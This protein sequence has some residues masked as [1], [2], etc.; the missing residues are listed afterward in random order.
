VDFAVL[1]TGFA[2]SIC[3]AMPPDA[4]GTFIR[5]LEGMADRNVSPAEAHIFQAVAEALEGRQRGSTET[6]PYRDPRRSC[7]TLNIKAPG[8][9]APRALAID[10]S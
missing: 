4:A 2:V 5:S 7:V 3:Q 10:L 6:R 8:V 1:F 9:G